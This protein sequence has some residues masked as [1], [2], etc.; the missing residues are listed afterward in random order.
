MAHTCPDCGYV[1]HCGGDID[2]IILDEFDEQCG[3]RHCLTCQSADDIEDSDDT[4]F[5]GSPDDRTPSLESQR[6]DALRR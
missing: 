1:C 6:R 5:D 4:D 3:C 2:D